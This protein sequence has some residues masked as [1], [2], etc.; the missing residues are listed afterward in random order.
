ML[1]R[2]KDSECSKL[3][4]FNAFDS[5]LNTS[6]KLKP[7][8]DSCPIFLSYMKNTSNSGHETT[9]FDLIL[10]RSLSVD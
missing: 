10:P 5:M 8:Q 1:Y 2:Y 9:G 4:P 6:F 3:L 7:K